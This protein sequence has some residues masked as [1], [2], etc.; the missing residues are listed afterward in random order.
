[1]TSDDKHHR[2]NNAHLLSDPDLECEFQ[3][4]NGDDQEDEDSKHHHLYG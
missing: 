3:D 2:R 1:M 4:R